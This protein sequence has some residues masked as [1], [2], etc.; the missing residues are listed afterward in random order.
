MASAP[1]HQYC[2]AAISARQEQ[3]SITMSKTTIDTRTIR[4]LAW[5]QAAEDVHVATS[6]GEFAGFVEVQDGRH[7]VRDNHGADLG[8]FATLGEARLALEG[9]AHA[10]K[11][12]QRVSKYS[13]RRIRRALA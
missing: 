7:I 4:A 6:N 11:R 1:D 2:G 12:R 9:L 5:K 8:S 10:P 3:L 13:L